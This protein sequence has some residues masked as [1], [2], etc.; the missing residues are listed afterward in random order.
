MV[1]HFR[2]ATSRPF[3]TNGRAVQVGWLLF[4]LLALTLALPGI[5]PYYQLFQTVCT[6]TAC[7]L[8]QLTPAELQIAFAFGNSLP[9]Y[10]TTAYYVY[11]PTYALLLLTAVAFIWRKPTHGAAVTGAFALTALATSTLAQA[12]AHTFPL[13]ERP[14]QF[15][16]FVQLALLL[17]FFSLIP[18]GR[19]QPA[20]FR[21][22]VLAIIPVAF[23][24]AFDM[25]G[26]G[27]GYVI[28]LIIG[29]LIVG[30]VI[31]R[32]RSLPPSPEKEQVAWTL[33]AVALLIGAQWMGRPLRPLPLPVI[34]LDAISY[35]FFGFFPVFGTLLIVGALTCLA[36][37]LLNDELFRVE[38]A[39]NRALVYTLLTLFVVG[40]YVLIVGY[41][42]LIFQS[43]GSLWFSLVATGLVAILFQPIR[44]RIQRFVNQLLYG[45]RDDPYHVLAHLGQRLESAFEPTAV[46]TAII[47]TIRE[48]L[49]LPYAAL[50]LHPESEAEPLA[51]SGVPVAQPASFPLTYQGATVGYLL[52]SPRRGDTSLTPADRA[53]LTDLAQQAGVAIH[54]VR[55]MADL[56]QL[57]AD[58]QHSRESLV[59]A[60]EEER[61]R[62][63]RDLHDDL[64]P[65]LVGLSLRASTI[66]DLVLTDP[67]KA[68]QLADNLD[69]AIRDAVGNI[70]RLVY[71]LRP[72]ALDNLGLLAAIRERANEYSN[73]RGLHI[74]VDAPETFP[75]LPAA[76]EVAAYRIVQEGL[77]NVVKHAQAHT[78][79]IHLR[80]ADGLQIEITD[81]GI[82]LLETDTAGVGLRSIQERTAEL[83]G[84]CELTAGKE[85]GTK[86]VVCL[87]I[88]NR[89]GE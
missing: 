41:L 8:G 60:R 35:T 43:R 1:A 67:A 32:Y 26:A 28:S 30:I 39:L 15:I 20:W 25:V 22:V 85:K 17:P 3:L 69:S 51:A 40:G 58:L 66:S 23:L 46:P 29:L 38:V 45:E 73:G 71:D 36:V 81:D 65:T 11:L 72:P 53:L 9:E 12:T 50:T 49:R 10:A 6:G 19:F 82:G 44:Q 88:A 4:L 5:V 57:T 24:V 70:R 18:D 54:G 80:L 75:P 31:Y 56:Q 42:S 14:S 47:Q 84:R 13:L 74:A 7:L 89:S 48:S 27:T 61:R 86:I 68:G 62:L 21:W 52:V 37:A 87:P 63:R 83:G 16:L 64:A 78:C 33:A 79:H 59:L 76:V 2:L 77:L 55:L 34:P